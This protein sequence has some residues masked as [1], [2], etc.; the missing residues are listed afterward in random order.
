LLG[1]YVDGKEQVDRSTLIK[2]AREAFGKS[3]IRG[4][5]R[6]MFRWI[7]AG[8]A[9]AGCAVVLV[10]LITPGSEQQRSFG[11]PKAERPLVATVDLPDGKPVH[12]NTESVSR[13]L[14]R[15][16]DAS[17]KTDD[18]SACLLSYG[19]SCPDM[20]GSFYSVPYWKKTLLFNSAIAAEEP[21]VVESR[22]VK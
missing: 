13:W 15:Q 16:R 7:L 5:Y 9:F 2:A 12:K 22:R 1:V 17:Y 19:F 8:L 14:S 3:E 18:V 4:Y 10:A 21:M 20:H 11:V 6:K